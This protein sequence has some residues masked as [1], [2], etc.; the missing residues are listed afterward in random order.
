MD[1][2]MWAPYMFVKLSL[3]LLERKH[4]LRQVGEVWLFGDCLGVLGG[5]A[6]IFPAG[7]LPP[8]TALPVPLVGV[9]GRG[10]SAPDPRWIGWGLRRHKDDANS[11]G[12]MLSACH[13]T[14]TKMELQKYV[15]NEWN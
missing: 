9:C 5:T 11:R 12:Q 15:W 13:G 1:V 6:F 7:T 14:S 4:T 3:T 2:W 10:S 8:S